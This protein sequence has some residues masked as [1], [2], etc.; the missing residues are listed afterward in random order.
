VYDYSHNV[1]QG[2]IDELTLTYNGNQLKSVSDAVDQTTVVTTNDF[3]DKSDATLPAEY[4]Y[5]TNGNQYANLN[6]GIAWIRYNVL[7]L[8]QKVQFRNGTTN[9]YVYDA[10]GVK[11][12]AKYSYSTS[13]SLIPLGATTTENTVASSFQ[14]DYC[15][16]YIYQKS[17][18]GNPKLLRILTPEGYISASLG[19]ISYMGYWTYTYFLRDHLGNTRV[20]LNSYYLSSNTNKTYGASDQIDYYPFG[21]ER[22]NTGQTSGGCFNSGTNP[23]LYNGKEID[24]MNGLN[25]ND[26]GG[27]WYDAAICRWSSVDPLAE[28]YYSISPYTY[29]AGNPVKYIDPNGMDWIKNDKTGI[30]EW[31]EIATKGHVPKG[32][33]YIGTEY[34]GI[35]IITFETKKF[36]YTDGEKEIKLLIEIGYKATNSNKNDGYN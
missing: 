16:N 5:D 13:T 8:P 23:Y 9:V 34:K 17:G 6:K 18:T 29:C 21:M 27:R 1:T 14:T 31:W 36:V 28:K 19:L 30:V 11:Q 33:S 32:Y 2:P 35:T 26:Y 24:R 25:E 22:S 12:Q 20:S 3:V 15:G 4:L 7:N 10:S